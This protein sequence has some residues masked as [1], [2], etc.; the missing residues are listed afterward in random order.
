MERP[1]F[2][3]CSKI[4]N[5]QLPCSLNAYRAKWSKDVFCSIYC[6]GSGQ[7]IR[8]IGRLRQACRQG[9][10]RARQKHLDDAVIPQR[11]TQAVFHGLIRFSRK[12]EESCKVWCRPG[13]PA[14]QRIDDSRR[15]WS[16]CSRTPVIKSDPG[17]I[18]LIQ[19]PGKQHA[20]QTKT[21]EEYRLAPRVSRRCFPCHRPK[22][23][24]L[25]L[26]GREKGREETGWS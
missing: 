5:A 13:Y 20:R 25:C 15:Q 16:G 23:S 4:A 12:R 14:T 3:R 11:D 2:H 10:L 22:V 24:A 26:L 21:N 8:G 17:D 9:I 1:G 7:A 18:T 19:K 6:A